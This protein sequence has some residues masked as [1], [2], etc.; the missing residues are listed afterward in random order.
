[1]CDGVKRLKTFQEN[2]WSY[3]LDP[4]LAAEAGFFAVG[5]GDQVECFWCGIVL[6]DW[7]KEFDPLFE[8]AKNSPRCPFIAGYS[9]NN[10][11]IQADPI[12]GANRR[13]NLDTAGSG[14][15]RM[16]RTFRQFLCC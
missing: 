7:K 11:P 8:H 2:E 15:R 10:K 6:I 14:V 5:V 1:M 13:L 3:P 16:K 12:R 4:I 9:V